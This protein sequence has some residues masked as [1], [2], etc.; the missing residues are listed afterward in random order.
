MEILT[1]APLIRKAMGKNRGVIK[2]TTGFGMGNQ[3]LTNNQ[4]VQ[5]RVDSNHGQTQITKEEITIL[6]ITSNS[7]TE[8]NYNHV[9]TKTIKG[10][11]RHRL[12]LWGGPAVEAEAPAKVDPGV[13]P[14][15]PV[16]GAQPE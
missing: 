8:I 5:G 9:A 11:H 3:T 2:R 15:A 6:T 10:C 1:P 14:E 4:A 16:E 13:D 7:V 12:H